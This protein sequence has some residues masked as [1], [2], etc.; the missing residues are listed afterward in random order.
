MNT[1]AYGSVER[2]YSILN[3]TLDE[4]L[5]SASLYDRFAI[6][7]GPQ[8][9]LYRTLDGSQRWSGRGVT[10]VLRW[11]TKRSSTKNWRRVLRPVKAH[12]EKSGRQ[13]GK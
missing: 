4:G 1:R 11:G 9:P 6:G 10:N 2:V 7:N 8:Y 3:S 13:N 5:W 12:P